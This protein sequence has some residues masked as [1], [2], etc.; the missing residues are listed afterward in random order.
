MQDQERP[1]NIQEYLPKFLEHRKADCIKAQSALMQNK[2]DEIVRV[3][4]AI[5]G[6]SRPFGFPD[7]E[8]MGL[9]LEEAGLGKEHDA[10]ERLI[11]A[12]EQ[13]I[14]DEVKKLNQ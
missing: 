1:D 3:G 2:Y 6:V 4:H 12:I 5:K 7:L 13:M 14:E 11:K 8:T 9:K 10:C